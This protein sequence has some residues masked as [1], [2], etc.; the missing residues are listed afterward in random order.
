MTVL[1]LWDTD[2]IFLYIWAFVY[3]I[4]LIVTKTGSKY[5]N[6]HKLH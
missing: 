2:N 3:T 1:L 5:T 6:L 4:A